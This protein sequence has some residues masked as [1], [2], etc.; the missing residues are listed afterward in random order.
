MQAE[1][2]YE[3]SIKSHYCPPLLNWTAPPSPLLHYLSSRP[4]LLLSM[5][6][7]GVTLSTSFPPPSIAPML[8]TFVA[9]PCILSY[10]SSS[11]STPFVPFRGRGIL[12]LCLLVPSLRL[13]T[14]TLTL[15]CSK[16]FVRFV[17]TKWMVL[18]LSISSMVKSLS[19]NRPLVPSPVTNSSCSLLL[20]ISGSPRNGRSLTLTSIRA[21][22]V[23]LVLPHLAPRCY[24]PIGITTVSRVGPAILPCFAMDPSVPLQSFASLKRMTL[25]ST[26][27]ACVCSLL[28]LLPSLSS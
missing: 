28:G 16:R 8:S 3:V 19:T 2:L 22:L 11:G 26:S 15:I 25:A 6:L 4:H 12:R 9:R 27:R 18:L 10:L 13:R 14:H 7:K 20:G 23:Y 5:L 24:V 21:S 1:Q 17:E